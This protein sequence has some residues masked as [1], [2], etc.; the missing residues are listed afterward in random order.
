MVHRLRSAAIV[1]LLGAAVVGGTAG[2]APVHDSTGRVSVE[3]RADAA[4]H[5]R[6]TVK[7]FDQQG[8][9]VEHQQV[10]GGQRADFAGVPLGRITVRASGLC[11]VHT[12]LRVDAVA[13]ATLGTSGCSA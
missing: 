13:H 12:T 11:A 5:H 6:Y 8:Q 1:G 3:V 10:F 9:M 7:V 4:A 2:C